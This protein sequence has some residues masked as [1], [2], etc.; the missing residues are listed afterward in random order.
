[1]I[2]QLNQLNKNLNVYFEIYNNIISYFDSSK[3]NYSL[4]QNINTM[5][6]YN[7]N[8]IGQLTEIIKDNNL[9]SQ[10]TKIINLQMAI[11]FKKLKNNNK[12]VKKENSEEKT[13]KNENQNK[14][15]DINNKDDNFE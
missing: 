2:N 12:Y 11:E 13:N 5:K 9:K 15:I 10:F 7:T 6:N 14:N 8:F 3:R 1:M 4:I